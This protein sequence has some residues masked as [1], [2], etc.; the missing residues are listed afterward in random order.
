M[1][2]RSATTINNILDAAGRLFTEKQYA[3]VSLREITEVAGV[4]KGALYHHFA[5]KEEL[6]L[7]A[8]YRC[9]AEVKET[10]EESHYSSRGE[11]CRSRLYLALGSFLRLPDETRAIMRSIRQN[12]NVFEEPIRTELIRTYQAALPQ[13]IELLL[14]EGMANGEII[15]MDARLLSWQHV[16]VVEVSLHEYGRQ[17]LGGPEEMADSIVSLFFNGIELPRTTKNEN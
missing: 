12:I 8:V 14:V 16:A 11:S 6:Y 4:T 1:Q 3:E 2:D 17:Q 7:Q 10:I 5:T 9:L 15:S 13:K